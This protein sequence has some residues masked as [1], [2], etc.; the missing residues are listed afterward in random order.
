MLSQNTVRSPRLNPTRSWHVKENLSIACFLRKCYRKEV[1]F[2][3]LA[4]RE[5][6]FLTDQLGKWPLAEIIL[7]GT[8]AIDS[9]AKYKL[10][11][12]LSLFKYSGFIQFLN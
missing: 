6:L 2:I 9:N 8:G 12:Q 11:E 10:E 7:S 4:G 3:H 1:L 5:A